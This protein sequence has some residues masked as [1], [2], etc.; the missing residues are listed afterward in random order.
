MGIIN[1]KEVYT[2][3]ET[4]A[5]LKVSRSTILRLIKKG[6]LRAGKLGGQYRIFG[7]DILRAVFPS[8][9]VDKVENTY[10]KVV[11]WVKKEEGK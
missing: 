4:Q 9:V 6:I 1:E 10:D 7:A 2:I 8:T 5:L 11:D 3:E